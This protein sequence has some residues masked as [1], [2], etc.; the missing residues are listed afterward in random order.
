MAGAEPV[1]AGRDQLGRVWHRPMWLYWLS[2]WTRAAHQLG[3]ALLLGFLFFVPEEPS[4]VLVWA[5]M[6]SGL[7][8]V[9]LEAVRH[10]EMYREFSGVVTIGKTLLLG[11]AMHQLLPRLPVFLLVFIVAALVAH[12]PKRLR[13]RVFW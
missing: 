10:R 1:K 3:V 4:S 11:A 12:A 8:L 9:M 5:A 2:L 6:G 7:V 13:H